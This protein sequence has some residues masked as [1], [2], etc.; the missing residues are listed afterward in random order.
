MRNKIIAIA[1]L[2]MTPALAY[3]QAGGGGGGGQ[4]GQGGQGGGTGSPATAGTAAPSAD[5]GTTSRRDTTTNRSA[6]RTDTSMRRD[7][8]LT[9]G[10]AGGGLAP[11]HRARSRNMGLSTD[12]VKELQQAING[13][14]CNAGPVDGRFG[15]E[16]RQGVQCVRQQKN[17][18]ENGLNPV[19]HALNL[20]FTASPSASDTS[21]MGG[22]RRMHPDT[23][24]TSSRQYQSPRNAQHGRGMHD[25]T[26]AKTGADTSHEK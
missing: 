13:A 16:T 25:S 8:S 12:Q 11:P 20:N 26:T 14:G 10:E 2:V 19:L 1:A 4:G 24:G 22:R 9:R 23:T 6:V 5:T 17:I 3:A 7:T 21:S 15:P 18:T